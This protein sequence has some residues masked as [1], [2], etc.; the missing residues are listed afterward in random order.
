MH[1]TPYT[2]NHTLYTT[3]HTPYTIHYT[4][5]TAGKRSEE[6]IRK[7]AEGKNFLLKFDREAFE[8]R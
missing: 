2:V 4:L 3:H 1:H 5:C 6:D 8:V 7:C